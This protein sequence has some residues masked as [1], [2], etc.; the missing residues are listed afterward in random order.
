MDEPVSVGPIFALCYNGDEGMDIMNYIFVSPNFPFGYYKWARSLKERGV[1]VLGIGD[2]PYDNLLPECKEA[3]DE[4]YYVY[5]LNDFDMMV[6]AVS[7]YQDRYGDIDYIESN[8]EWWLMLDSRLREKFHVKSGFYPKDMMKIKSKSCMKACFEKGGAKTMRYLLVNGPEDIEKAKEFAAKVSYPLFVKP[9]IGVGA[10]SS[11]KLKDEK[12]LL[13]FLSKPLEETYIMEEYIDGYIV[14]FDGVCDSNSDVVF[15]STTHFPTPV[16][17]IVNGKKDECYYCNPFSLKMDDIDAKRFKKV[18]KDVVKAFG[19]KKRCFHIE[20][21]V[22]KKDKEGFAKKGEFVALECNMRPAGGNLPDLTDFANSLSI[23][24]IYADVICYDENRQDM[25]QEKFY[26][27]ASH[28]R[29]ELDYRYLDL[30]VVYDYEKNLCMYGRYP[31]SLSDAMCDEY[32]Y[33]TFRT[34][35]EGYRFDAEVREKR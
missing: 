6:K 31:K 23:Y 5:N 19:I 12:E 35:D 10:A 21:F 32:F 13:A 27:F 29:D 33:A 17:D 11:F 2:T 7:Y 9:D 34:K 18:G 15:C 3:L 22:L 4:Y 16:A 20:F 25:D 14:S 30:K 24:D 8:N 28:R 26:A 1:R